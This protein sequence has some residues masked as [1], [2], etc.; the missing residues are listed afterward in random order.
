MQ[1]V[2][3][4]KIDPKIKLNNQSKSSNRPS[5]LPRRIKSVFDAADLATGPKNDQTANNP[6]Q[7]GTRTFHRIMQINK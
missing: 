7:T 3:I 2:M 1:W 6:P 5:P 4:K